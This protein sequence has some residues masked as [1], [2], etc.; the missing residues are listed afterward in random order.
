MNE[1]EANIDT[2]SPQTLQVIG[3]TKIATELLSECIRASKD[4]DYSEKVNQFMDHA[5]QLISRSEE[6]NINQAEAAMALTLVAT[7]MFSDFMTF[8]DTQ[9]AN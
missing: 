6:W 2:L 9:K 8:S 7:H 4:P 5:S 1:S 3:T